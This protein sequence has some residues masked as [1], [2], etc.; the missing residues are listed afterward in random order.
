MIHAGGGGQVDEDTAS[1][2]ESDPAA[3]PSLSSVATLPRVAVG[4]EEED[5]DALTSMYKPKLYSFVRRKGARAA[6]LIKKST[7]RSSIIGRYKKR[8]RDS[9]LQNQHDDLPEE[10]PHVAVMRMPFSVSNDEDI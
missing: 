9:F 10:K 7:T 3:T 8:K 2:A 1:D 5:D 6:T 4:Q